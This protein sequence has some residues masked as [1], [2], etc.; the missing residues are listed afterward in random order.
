ML[1]PEQCRAARGL[2]DLTQRELALRAGLTHPLVANFER[3]KRTP[4]LENL[5]RIREALE[6]AGVEF[7]PADETG[8]PGVRLKSPPTKN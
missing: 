3:R 4:R 6:E 5:L 8:G 1:T 7:I 2:I